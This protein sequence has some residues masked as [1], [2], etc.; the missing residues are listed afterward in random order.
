MNS[1]KMMMSSAPSVLQNRQ[2]QGQGQGIA[3]IVNDWKTEEQEDEEE[4]EEEDDGRPFLTTDRMTKALRQELDE[5]RAKN[6]IVQVR[7]L[8][9]VYHLSIC[10]PHSSISCV[11][12]TT[13]SASI[14]T[15]LYYTILCCAVC[16]CAV[17]SISE[18]GGVCG[19]PG[20]GDAAAAEAGEGAAGI[21]AHCE[22]NYPDLSI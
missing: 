16:V 18:D 13:S 20:E 6:N 15:H 8:S 17:G 22:G 14:I 2:G 3:D 11:I 5:L 9:S 1:T 4:Q 10:L 12:N 7:Y 19:E 21:A